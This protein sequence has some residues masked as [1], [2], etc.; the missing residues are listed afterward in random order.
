MLQ[1]QTQTATFWRDQFEVAPDDLDFT[2][3]LLLD[4]QAPRTLSEL[5]IALI[6]EYVR[7]EDAKIQSELAKG[8][9]YQPR[10]RYQVG[11]KLVF[12]AWILPWPK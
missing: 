1:R 5:S 8:E 9:L 6:S 11:Q 2:Y 7:K 12:P 10:N 3:N 4:A